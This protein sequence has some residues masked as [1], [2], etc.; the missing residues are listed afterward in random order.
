LLAEVNMKIR[1]FLKLCAVIA[2]SALVLCLCGFEYLDSAFEKNIENTRISDKSK[3]A[4]PNSADRARE[5]VLY[6][7]ITGRNSSVYGGL[8]F[9]CKY[10]KYKCNVVDNGICFY[11]TN[12]RFYYSPELKICLYYRIWRNVSKGDASEEQCR[13]AAQQGLY[14]VFSK[15][16]KIRILKTDTRHKDEKIFVFYVYTNMTDNIPVIISVARDNCGILSFDAKDAAKALKKT[17]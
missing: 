5:M 15:Y 13:S 17:H 12:Q 6:K 14:R 1:T 10:I 11:N 8:P 16:G 4:L 2:F 7:S 3:K 9:L